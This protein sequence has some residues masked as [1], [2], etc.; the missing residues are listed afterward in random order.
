MLLFYSPYWSTI[1]TKLSRDI[2]K[3]NG[4][5]GKDTSTHVITY[6]LWCSSNSLNDDSIHL[7]VFQIS[8]TVIEVKWY[9]E[10]P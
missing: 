5:P 6:H 9:V 1:D 7:Q 4:N 3:F 10:F 2:L 8:L